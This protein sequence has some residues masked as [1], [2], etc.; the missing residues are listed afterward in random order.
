MRAGAG[1][2][3]RTRWPLLVLS[4]GTLSCRGERTST[5]E[6]G[7]PSS[8]P[9]IALLPT[10]ARPALLTAPECE[11]LWN[12]YHSVVPESPFADHDTFLARCAR[13]ERAVL[14]CVGRTKAEVE[15]MFEAVLPSDVGLPS[16]SR[17]T[18]SPSQWPRASASA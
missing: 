4:L 1:V 6:P 16:R 7:T 3:T 11:R 17:A 5:A 14:G 15:T 12:E 9:S 8:A 10:G 2:L 13:S 18:S